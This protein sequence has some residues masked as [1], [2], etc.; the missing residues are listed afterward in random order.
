MEIEEFIEQDILIYLDEILER[1]RAPDK[2]AAAESAIYLTR[3]YEKEL[4][5]ALDKRDIPQAKKV[6]HAL[7]EQF[8]QCPAGTQDKEQLRMLLL[9]LYRKFKEHVDTLDK[10]QQMDTTLD[11]ALQPPAPDEAPLPPN[12]RDE[13]LQP[14]GAEMPDATFLT[15]MLDDA[16]LH[17]VNG[18]L[19]EAVDSYRLARQRAIEANVLVAPDLA[20]RFKGL[21]ARIKFELSQL[22]Q[23]DAGTAAMSKAMGIAPTPVM[24]QDVQQS[25]QR[26]SSGPSGAVRPAAQ[27]PGSQ[28]ATTAWS[29]FEQ[30][31]A[32]ASSASMSE[33]AIPDEL[34]ALPSLTS[35]ELDKQS[36]LQLEQEK[37]LLDQMLQRNDLAGSMRQYKRMRMIAQQLT[38]AQSSEQA[39]QKLL[40]IY[41]LINDMKSHAANNEAALTTV[42]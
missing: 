35:Q 25:A 26:L 11:E 7:K 4:F 39:A 32:Q 9:E 6:L 12:A 38:D 29:T 41:E 37:Q 19:R 34:P 13:A 1:V 27:A 2:R 17:F 18:E 23:Q 3:D 21:Y 28:R 40:R 24:I 5:A 15:G 31:T 20:L 42:P 33:G 8:D 22:D 36:L 14:A 30:Q 16:E 10:L